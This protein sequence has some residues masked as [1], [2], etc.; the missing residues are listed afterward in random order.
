MSMLI[1]AALAARS[2]TASTIARKTK[3]TPR[4]RTLHPALRHR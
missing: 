3:T 2:A 1:A 4:P